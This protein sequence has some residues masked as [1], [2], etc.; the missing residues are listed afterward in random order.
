MT[1]DYQNNGAARSSGRGGSGAGDG[2]RRCQQPGVVQVVPVGGAMETNV[3]FGGVFSVSAGLL[4]V[5]VPTFVLTC[6]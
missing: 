6:V 3:V 5:P 2:C 1:F 4:A